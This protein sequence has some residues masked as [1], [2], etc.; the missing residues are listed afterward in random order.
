MADKKFVRLKNKKTGVVSTVPV[1]LAKE[2]L[3]DK[4]SDLVET[5]EE[6]TGKIVTK[7]TVKK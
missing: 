6:I 4:S 2:L 1:G 7:K 3:K 5:K